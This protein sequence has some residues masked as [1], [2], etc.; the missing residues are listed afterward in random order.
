MTSPLVACLALL[1]CS[2]SRGADV[3]P[4]QAT[5]E[6]FRAI[7]R[8]VAAV[9]VLE[10]F[11]GFVTRLEQTE[12]L[13]RLRRSKLLGAAVEGEITRRWREL[14]HVLRARLGMGLDVL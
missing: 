5:D 6:L 10:D 7:P 14:D 3:Q 8:E 2:A 11:D 4:K 12:G 13:K 1:F 9:A